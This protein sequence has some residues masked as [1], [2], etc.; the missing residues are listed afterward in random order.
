[1]RNKIEATASDIESV[2]R[3]IRVRE[4]NRT[5]FHNVHSSSSA[6][7]PVA[8]RILAAATAAA[9]LRSLGEEPST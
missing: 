2:A 1:M 5:Y 3:E 4:L 7:V 6:H 9:E 8:E